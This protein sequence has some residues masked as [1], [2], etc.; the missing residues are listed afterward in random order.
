ML[1]DTTNTFV[2]TDKMRLYD[3]VVLAGKRRLRP[4]LMTTLTTVLGLLPL[5]FEIGDGSESQAPMARV[6]IG[7][8][9]SSTIITLVVIPLIYYSIFKKRY[10][11]REQ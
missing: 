11:D 2:Q 9:M 6:V 7:G 3:A 10:A 4:I 8:L 1:I 5:A